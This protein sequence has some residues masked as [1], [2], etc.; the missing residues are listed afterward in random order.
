[1]IALSKPTVS[2]L[3]KLKKWL[4]LPEAARHLSGICGEEV[5]EADILRLALDKHL[6]LSVNFVNYTHVKPGKVVD[7]DDEKLAALMSQGKYTSALDWAISLRSGKLVLRSLR[8]GE[9][10]YLKIDEDQVVVIEDVWDL[11]MI[12]GEIIYVERKYHELIGGPLVELSDNNG[13]FVSGSDG[14]ICKLQ[15]IYDDFYGCDAVRIKQLVKLQRLERNKSNNKRKEKLLALRRE[16]LNKPIELDESWYKLGRYYSA[17]TF[18]EDAMLVVRTDALIE[19]E[20]LISDSEVEHNKTA[21]SNGHKE[22]HA[23]NR[24]QVLGAAFAVYTEWSDECRDA[25][26]KPV[27]SKIANLVEAK[28]NLF[29][30]NAEPPLCVDS[31]ADHLRDW[32]KKVNNRK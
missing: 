7:F 29:W 3:F 10:K 30:P 2:K 4:T 26:G 12:G 23:Q 13:T 28:S 11:P 31:I 14:T 5:T 27:A 6:T 21:K 8:I 9:G 1:V 16:K 18:P 25:K 24:E 32:I 20:Q 19:F 22:R 15:D 17:R